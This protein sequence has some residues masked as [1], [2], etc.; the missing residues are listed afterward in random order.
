MG[1]GTRMYGFPSG[2]LPWWH[3]GVFV[4]AEV[5]NAKKR[6]FSGGPIIRSGTGLRRQRA[7]I[8]ASSSY[9]DGFYILRQNY[10]IYRRIISKGHEV[11]CLRSLRA[12]DKVRRFNSECR[13]VDLKREYWQNQV[14]LNY[15]GFCRNWKWRFSHN[16]APVLESRLTIRQMRYRPPLTHVDCI[17]SFSIGPFL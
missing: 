5:G 17:I 9:F 10:S 11:E 1:D 7:V 16:L 6:N 13:L 15:R 4:A 12:E 3:G 2:L 14:L 8:P